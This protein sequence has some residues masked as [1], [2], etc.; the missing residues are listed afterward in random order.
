[1][2]V[3]EGIAHGLMGHEHEADLAQVLSAATLHPL[4]QCCCCLRA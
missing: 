1:M 2:I 3:L 4:R